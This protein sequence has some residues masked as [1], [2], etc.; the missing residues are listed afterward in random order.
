[1]YNEY[2]NTNK[3][4]PDVKIALMSDIH[5]APKYK[6]KILDDLY[7]QIIE[8]KPDY[9]CITGDILDNALYK[10]LDPLIKWFEDLAKISPVIIVYG[11][12]DTK[13]GYRHHWEEEQNS[14]LRNILNNIDNIHF[15]EDKTW[16]DNNIVFYGYNPSY[17]YYE[18]D[19]EKYS[20]FC[21]EMDKTHCPFKEDNYNILLIHTPINI[22]KY[23][24]NNPNTNLAKT[25]LI[26]SGHTHNGCIPFCITR[27]FNKYFKT[28]R[29]LINPVRIFF[30]KY[31]QGKVYEKPEGF[32]HQAIIKFAYSTKF[33]SKFDFFYQKKVEFINIKRITK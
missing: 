5:Y 28:T 33:Y 31:T 6:T 1:M 14:H 8:N 7:N 16:Q 13:K 27:F 22:Y 19:R 12:H 30:A 4:I 11:N 29:S 10:K 15:L 23:I 3:K 17:K 24:Q 26:L 18:I 9:I 20:S 32:I 21:H 25:D 2:F